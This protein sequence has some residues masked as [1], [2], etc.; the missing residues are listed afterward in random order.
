[1]AAVDQDRRGVPR[2]ENIAVKNGNSNN[3]KLGGGSIFGT[4]RLLRF[5]LE[6][7]YILQKRED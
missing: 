6:K 5:I 2:S 7:A 1:M 3:G 4:G